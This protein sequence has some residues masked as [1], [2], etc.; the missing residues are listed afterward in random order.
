VRRRLSAATQVG[1][2]VATACFAA[3]GSFLR[4][5]PWVGVF[6]LCIG[7]LVTCWIVW[8]IWAEERARRAVRQLIGATL[9]R[10]RTY[11]DGDGDA[12]RVVA[13]FNREREWVRAALGDVEATLLTDFTRHPSVVFQPQEDPVLAS[14]RGFRLN[15]TSLNERLATLD[16]EPSFR[17]RDWTDQL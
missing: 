7:G 15:L 9:Q 17:P 3:G 4:A 14:L 16:L 8:K 12:E 6:L 13:F 10:L 11:E 5:E 2:P 1:L